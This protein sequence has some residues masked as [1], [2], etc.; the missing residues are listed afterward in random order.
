MWLDFQPIFLL[1]LSIDIFE[2]KA[3]EVA[4]FRRSWDRGIEWGWEALISLT[5]ESLMAAIPQG[6]KWVGW[7]NRWGDLDFLAAARYSER[8]LQG[9]RVSELSLR[10]LIIAGPLLLRGS[11]FLAR[12]WG[13]WKISKVPSGSILRELSSLINE[14]SSEILLPRARP[15]RKR[16]FLVRKSKDLLFLF[17]IKWCR[18][19]SK[20]QSGA[21]N[22]GSGLRLAMPLR[23][24]EIISLLMSK[25]KPYFKGSMSA[26]LYDNKVLALSFL[27][28]MRWSKK[29]INRLL[30]IVE[31][32]SEWQNSQNTFQS[33]SY[34]LRVEGLTDEMKYLKLSY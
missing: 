29:E 8:A 32:L 28:L 19:R 20:D 12:N 26:H 22:L 33:C 6:P 31:Q 4:T 18:T 24:L 3:R 30:L 14:K 16:V 21:L 34:W 27:C 23:L 15:T 13:S 11:S 9:Q 5:I 2:K 25:L 1:M 7:T 10:G 17:S